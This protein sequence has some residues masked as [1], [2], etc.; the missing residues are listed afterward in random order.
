MSDNAN[1]GVDLHLEG[2]PITMPNVEPGH[3]YA[4]QGREQFVSEGAEFEVMHM[5]TGAFPGER[6]GYFDAGDKIKASDLGEGLDIGRLVRL[7]ALRPLADD[8]K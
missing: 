2:Q 3:R 1:I 5:I 6:R 4:V 7:G 8:A